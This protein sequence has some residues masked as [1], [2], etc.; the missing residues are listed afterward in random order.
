MKNPQP[1]HDEGKQRHPKSCGCARCAPTAH[2]RNNYFTGKL[3]TA[4]DFK[5]EQRYFLDKA[6]RHNLTLHGWGIVCGLEVRPHPNCPDKRLIVTPGV[7][8][9]ACGREIILAGRD[10][11]IADPEKEGGPK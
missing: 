9:D 10:L 2:C 7:A 11:M 4:R 6:R 5:D 8:V 3:L 1:H